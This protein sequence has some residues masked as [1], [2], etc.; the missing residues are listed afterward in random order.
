MF[1]IGTKGICSN[2]VI[3]IATTA[4]GLVIITLVTYANF[5]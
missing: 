2:K 5:H 1:N 4:F 3:A